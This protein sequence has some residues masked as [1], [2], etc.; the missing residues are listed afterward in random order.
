[1]R[2]GEPDREV[3]WFELVASR[4]RA[5][6]GGSLLLFPRDVRRRPRAGA[7][8]RRILH[9]RGRRGRELDREVEWLELVGTRQR[10]EQRRR[11]PG[12]VRRRQRASALRR[13]HVFG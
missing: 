5:E 12:D 2:D 3:E 13:R 4:K 11:C 6:R 1:R 10:D 9:G 8:R 7:L